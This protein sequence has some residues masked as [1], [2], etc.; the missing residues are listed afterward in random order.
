MTVISLA[1]ISFPHLLT[2]L[3]TAI[4]PLCYRTNALSCSCDK[5]LQTRC[6]YGA[7]SGDDRRILRLHVAIVYIAAGGRPKLA[8]VLTSR[9]AS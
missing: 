3:L 6:G 4:G 2:Y 7:A 1:I 5:I 8:T 9:I